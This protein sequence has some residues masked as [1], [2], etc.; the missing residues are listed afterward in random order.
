MAVVGD[1]VAAIQKLL[2]DNGHAVVYG[3]CAPLA[4]PVDK[5]T[6]EPTGG[7]TGFRTINNQLERDGVAGMLAGGLR[8]SWAASLTY[9]ETKDADLLASRKTEKAGGAKMAGI[10]AR[11]LADAAMTNAE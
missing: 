6:G 9:P 10:D 3:Q 8:A 11:A 2:E 7:S 5:E 1:D 4:R